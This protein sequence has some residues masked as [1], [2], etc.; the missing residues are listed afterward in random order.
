MNPTKNPSQIL[1]SSIATFALLFL[2]SSGSHAATFV[3]QQGDL[4]KDGTTVSTSFVAPAVTL[5]GGVAYLNTNQ[6]NDGRILVGQNGGTGPQNGAFA[7]DLSSINA[8]AAAAGETVQINSVS[9]TLTVQGAGQNLLSTYKLDLLGNGSSAY[10]FNEATAT[11]NTPG[12]SNV[13]GG[14]LGTNLSSLSFNPSTQSAGTLD[15]WASTSAFTTAAT[16]ALA[17]DGVLRLIL[18]STNVGDS[19]KTDLAKFYAND[20]LSG[21]A[22]ASPTVAEHPYLSVDYTLVEPEQV[23]EPSSFAL[24]AVSGVAMLALLR[25]KS[26]KA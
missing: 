15:T 24:M 18:T 22:S 16:N 19:S 21:G 7:F 6:N 2:G 23:P 4:V 5:R 11:W 9:L 14:T 17:G 1:R 25:R 12:G 13:A 8:V 26:Q 10:N 3:F 20:P